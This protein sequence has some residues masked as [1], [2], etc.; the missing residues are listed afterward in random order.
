MLR[1]RL[2]ATAVD[3]IASPATKDSPADTTASP[4]TKDSPAGRERLRVLC[5]MA[6]AGSLTLRSAD[7][8]TAQ[9]PAGSVVLAAK[10][11]ALSP[12]LQDVVLALTAAPDNNVE[13]IL[14]LLFEA[15]MVM[16]EHLPDDTS[17]SSSSVTVKREE[18][19]GGDGDHSPSAASREARAVAARTQY[20][21][22]TVRILREVRSRVE[23]DSNVPCRLLLE[24]PLITSTILAEV[25][26]GC[27]EQRTMIPSFV[28]LRAAVQ[29]RP[30]CRIEAL[31]R[32]LALTGAEEIKIRT[33]AINACQHLHAQVPME[34][35][36][37]A[38][39][40]HALQSLQQAMT[41]AAADDGDTGVVTAVM[42]GASLQLALLLNAPGLMRGLVET[43]ATA[44]A[45]PQRALLR[46]VASF[47]PALKTKVDMPAFLGALEPVPVGAETLVLKVL[48]V[49]CADALPPGVAALAQRLGTQGD[50]ADARYLL[51]LLPYKSSEQVLALLPLLLREL[52]GKDLEQ[53]LPRLLS[54]KGA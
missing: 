41:R 9:V 45:A 19:D 11:D 6:V 52:Q 21:A 1:R 38:I 13:H 47:V 14:S 22:L 50:A 37:G 29:L 43:Y 3:S 17:A 20:E 18:H 40:E 7:E 49:L 15:W 54:P 42:R 10:G 25:E 51:P 33:Q 36:A 39:E 2:L 16:G 8:S 26:L 35:V 48:D 24:A 44:S 28:A 30:P 34:L 12:L 23:A 27:H 32:L 5:R 31:Q 46:F 4:A 53:L